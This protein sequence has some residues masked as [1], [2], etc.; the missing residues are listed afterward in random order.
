MSILALYA[1]LLAILFVFLSIRIIGLR[2]K[3]QIGLGDHSNH[4]MLRA[5]RVHSNFSEYVPL[6]LILIY[7]VEAQAAA[8]W[9]VHI[10]GISLLIGRLLHAYGVSKA[11]ENFRFRVS[12]MAMTFTPI[13]AS[14]IY[15]LFK[16]ASQLLT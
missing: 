1:S 6:A 16:E 10:L 14:A 11:K 15:L 5:I 12:G 13:L 7:L 2:R 9:F 3:L 8:A 4:E